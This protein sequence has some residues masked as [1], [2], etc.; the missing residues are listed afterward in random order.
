MCSACGMSLLLITS[1]L[2]LH[3]D[4]RTLPGPASEKWLTHIQ[5]VFYSTTALD[6]I[7]YTYDVA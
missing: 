7:S 5:P 3:G 2:T 1:E 4:L 6:A